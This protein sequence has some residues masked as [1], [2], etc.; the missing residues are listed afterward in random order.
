MQQS[1]HLCQD[2]GGFL[3]TLIDALDLHS[4]ECLILSTLCHTGVH[5][6]EDGSHIGLKSSS[7][8]GL[9]WVALDD[10]DG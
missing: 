10:L 4:V 8:G 1:D 7:V 6:I 3:G 2:T 5:S 9:L